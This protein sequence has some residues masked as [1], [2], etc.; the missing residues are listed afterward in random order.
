MNRSD[1]KLGRLAAL[2]AAAL[3]AAGYDSCVPRGD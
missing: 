3:V 1:S 2:S